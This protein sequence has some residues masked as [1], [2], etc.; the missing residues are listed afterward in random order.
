MLE[1]K[2]ISHTFANKTKENK[3]LA[4][5]NLKIKKGEFASLIG[6]SGCGKTTLVNII[7]GYL[8]PA[9]GEISLNK[10][11]ILKPGIDRIVINQENDLF[12]WMTVF[13][14][15]KLA[16]NNLDKIQKLLKLTNLEAYKNFYPAKLS[17]GMKKRLS[18]ARALASDPE[19]IIMDEPFSSQDINTKNKLHKELLD[20]ARE[21]NKTI[22]LV[23]H[24]LEEAIFLSDRIIVLG[25]SPAKIVGEHKVPFERAANKNIKERIEYNEL[26]SQLASLGYNI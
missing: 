17:G 18:L 23:T 21:S 12:E 22:L 16:T 4:G 10:K 6:P 25:G 14:H 3:V 13:D 11:R 15:L 1:L 8:K 9:I 20:I 19:F 26:R 2:N 7:A 5:I 24:D